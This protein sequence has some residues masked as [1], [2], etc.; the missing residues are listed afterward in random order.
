MWKLVAMGY[1]VNRF[2]DE[3]DT[4]LICPICHG[5]LEDPKQVCFHQS[6][7]IKLL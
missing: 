1:D 4:D 5:V 6:Y 2:V 3:V 7:N